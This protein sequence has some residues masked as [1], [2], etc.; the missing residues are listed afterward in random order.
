[1][2]NKHIFC[3]MV[4]VAIVTG[5]QMSFA[6]QSAAPGLQSRLANILSSS[7]ETELLEP[8]EAF[9][10]YAYVKG[11]TTVM[12]ELTPA[13]GYYLYKPRIKFALKDSPGV[14]FRAVKLPVGEIKTDQVYGR[15]ETYS[16]PIQ[17]EIILDRV[18]NAKNLT[19][20][21]GYQGCHEK[22]GVCY[23]PMDKELTLAL[24]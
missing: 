16:K 21:A 3:L 10:F 8:D 18:P 15:S 20:V 6:Q 13:K 9:K 7:K 1:M 17:V 22:T 5:H 2:L 24:P 23:P 12:A 19:V 4:T 11:P 14:A